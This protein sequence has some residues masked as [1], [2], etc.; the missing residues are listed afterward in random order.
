M[1]RRLSAL[2]NTLSHKLARKNSFLQSNNSLYIEQ[3][4]NDWVSDPKSV[5]AS[6]NAYFNSVSAGVDP[7]HAFV[8]P[9]QLDGQAISFQ[10]QKSSS[11][12][13]YEKEQYSDIVGVLTEVIKQFRKFGHYKA[14]IDP[15]GYDG[16]RPKFDVNTKF[17]D[18]ENWDI[19]PEKLDEPVK[20]PDSLNIGF[21]DEKAEWTP[22]ELFERLKEVY[23]GKIGFEYMHI[24]GTEECDWIRER[25]ERRT[26]SV[27]SKEHKLDLLDR[28]L[29]SQAFSLYCEKKFSTAK[30]FGCEGIDVCISALNRLKQK[31][32]E[33]DIKEI[34]IGM[35]HRGRLNTLTCVME[36]P[37]EHLFAE[38]E[39]VKPKAGSFTDVHDFTG[40]VKYHLGASTILEHRDGSSMRLVLLP[41]PSHLETVN[42]VVMGSV[43]ARQDSMSEEC[44]TKV[45]PVIIH[46]DAAVAGQGINY[47]LQQLEKVKN[48]EVNG[49]IHIVFNN[50]VGFTTDAKYGR[51]GFYCTNISQM[52]KNLVIHVNADDPELC[53]WAMEL[54]VDFRTQFR[55]DVYIDIVGYRKLGHNEQD[56]PRFTQPKM[57]ELI[58]KQ[59]PM[60]LL[61]KEKLIKEGVITQEQFDNKLNKYMSKLEEHHK[62]AKS[63]DFSVTD[64]DRDS[65][66]KLVAANDNKTY[67]K[68]KNLKAVAEQ[69]FTLKPEFNAHKVVK[70]LYEERLKSVNEGTHIDWGTAELLA[71]GS[72]LSEGHNLRI[73]GEDVMRGTFSHRH[74]T[75]VD[76]K[77]GEE[78]TPLKQALPENRNHMCTV[79]NSIL[80][81][82][83]VLGFEYGYSIASPQGLTIWE[84]QFG[85]FTNGA[86]I[87]VDQ[88]ITS[89]EKK[90]GKFSGLTMLLPHGYD[91]QGPEHSNARLERFLMNMSDDYFYLADNRD[92]RQDIL[93]KAN[94]AVCNVTS[95]ANYFHLLRSQVKY[96]FRKPLVVM[97]PKKLLRSKGARS[98]IEEFLEPN[99][100]KPVI[101]DSME[102]KKK[103]KKILV[104][105]GQIYFDL[106]EKRTE[107]KLDDSVAIIRLE[108]LGPF[109]YITFEKIIQQYSNDAPVIFVQEEHINFGAWFYVQPRMDLI[110]Q[111][112]GFSEARVIGRHISASP[113]TGY[114]HNH[115]RQHENL[116]ASAF[117]ASA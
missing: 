68:E 69:I 90:W 59:K 66:N 100:F 11:L 48:F 83:G 58:D 75:L 115:Q 57:Y 65:F 61:Y 99:S 60:Y 71:Y 10:A 32:Y 112:Q 74:A 33:K 31:A 20:L 15:L 29:E 63:G 22:R 51:S 13:S 45:L 12:H 38:F 14:Q 28:I 40:D 56:M 4:Y 3:M 81:E 6:W 94:M 73:T 96:N 49:S 72:L 111:E 36:K 85:D 30:R 50:Q 113:A 37:Y 43:K 46:G 95:A 16:Y 18:I 76:Q 105:S 103:A 84:A 27:Y 116:I 17:F 110:L 79:A 107:L 9:D 64:M 77:T 53:D 117:E 5:H 93:R 88:Y 8:H 114:M 47:E 92:A 67:V 104:C 34:V 52:N 54:A 106:A 35:A 86:Q 82:Y 108:R 101:D 7:Q 41:N 25:I 98:N 78:Y 70:K 24:P 97:S 91:G 109:P 87:V 21:T 80:S 19:A 62:I 39:H 44:N 1:L 2:T 102:D 26:R 55:R 23:C 42:S 89:G